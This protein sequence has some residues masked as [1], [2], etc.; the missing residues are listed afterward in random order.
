VITAYFVVADQIITS[1]SILLNFSNNAPVV[2]LRA[3]N[4]LPQQHMSQEFS[5]VATITDTEDGS[6]EDCTITWNP[7]PVTPTNSRVASFRFGTPGPQT[8]EVT[9]EDR[10]GA[11]TTASLTVDIVNTAP[12]VTISRPLDGTTI[13]GGNV[14]Y[15]EGRGY[16]LNTGFLPCSRLRWASS[17]PTDVLTFSTGCS[18]RIQVTDPGTRTI[19]LV[20]SDGYVDS[21]P[22]TATVTVSACGTAGCPPTAF[23]TFSAPNDATTGVYYIESEMTI[24][25]QI[26]D[27]E[28][29]EPITYRVFGRR[30]GETTT[31]P[32]ATRSVVLYDALTMRI[33]DELWTPSSSIGIG[34]P[35]CVW[36]ASSRDYEIVLEATDS[37]GMTTT[38][39]RVIKLGCAFI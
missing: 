33:Q 27:A 2:S 22:A 7:A 21:A 19:T 3:S 35:D 34:W 18:T 12:T 26:G 29:N 4:D 8:I 28:E 38:F 32:I 39:S 11:T 36:P 20:A 23:F 16:D 30:V 6:C 9:V 10:G 31:F 25:V 13:S 5:V 24:E 37:T 14:F 15:A 1:R 17:N